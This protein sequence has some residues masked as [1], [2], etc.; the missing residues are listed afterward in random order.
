M[1]RAS[2]EL[3]CRE[4]IGGNTIL[5]T[6]R[7]RVTRAAMLA[8][9]QNFRTLLERAKGPHWII[10]TSQLD[11]FEPGAV[12]V[13]TEWFRTFKSHGG[14][15]V[16]FVSGLATARMAAGTIAFAAR[17]P[18]V[19]VDSLKQAFIELG[20]GEPRSTVN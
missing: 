13:G 10:D 19:S 15:R 4:V 8:E 14:Q 20:I 11:D 7:A 5:L 1:N 16:V 2:P 3:T 17:L 18:L 9:L 12:A 6:A